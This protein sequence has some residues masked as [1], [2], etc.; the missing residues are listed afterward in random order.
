MTTHALDLHRDNGLRVLS[1]NHVAVRTDDA[2]FMIAVPTTVRL[3]FGT[4][5][6]CACDPRAI[7]NDTKVQP[8]QPGYM[9]LVEAIGGTLTCPPTIRDLDQVDPVTG[10]AP[11]VANPRVEYYPGTSLIRH[12]K[13]T[14]VC[15]TRN[16]ESSTL[17][18]SVQTITQDAEHILRQ[19][20]LGDKDLDERTDVM[21]ILS[22]DDVDA[23]KKDGKLRGWAVIPLT[24]PYA[25]ICANMGSPAVRECFS[26]F[27]NQSA[28]IRQRACSKAER[29]AADH[30]PVT[31]K[32]WVYGDLLQD[33][34]IQGEGKVE[35]VKIA[36][37]DEV[38]G[39]KK[40]K[41]VSPAYIDIATV[42]WVERRG[43]A[44]LE[45]MVE[46][47]A[48]A[49]E[50]DGVDQIIRGDVVDITREV[51]FEEAAPESRQL[52]EDLEED[53]PNG[54]PDEQ[55]PEPVPVETTAAEAPKK[56]AKK[57]EPAP[58]PKPEPTNDEDPHADLREECVQMEGRL[59][60]EHGPV[61]IDACLDSAGLSGISIDQMDETQ[62]GAYLAEMRDA[63]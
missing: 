43:Q 42:T 11:L 48:S 62:L 36:E 31:R 16:P 47:L 25:N 6:Y 20:L 29:L 37:R 52:T 49:S 23:D 19:A 14:A 55:K 57:P 8:F 35:G 18:A 5:L 27:Q 24:P 2:G 17:T 9:K 4:D 10:V 12:V 56:A 46:M 7:K 38:V 26:T 13:A 34:F 1:K 22:D 39:D 50:V 44:E 63:S 30:N 59:L 58:E 28:T 40:W 51:D 53:L 15:I 61:A 60:D 45:E 54:A 3:H 21:Q 41:V 32:T 33:V